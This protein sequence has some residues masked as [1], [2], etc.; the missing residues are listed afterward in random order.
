MANAQQPILIGSRAVAKRGF[1][2][3][4]VLIAAAMGIIVTGVVAESFF[5]SWQAQ[6]SQEIYS[7]LQRAS[8]SSL[9]EISKQ[10]WNATSVTSSTILGGT[11]YTSGVSTLVL[12]LPPLNNNGDII[13]GDDYLIFQQNGANTV[14]LISPNASSTRAN[15]TTPITINRDTELLEFQY[16]NAAGTELI[17]G[18]NDLTST[19]TIT[20]TA[21]SSRTLGSRIYKRE[22]KSTILLRNKAV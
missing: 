19:R 2:L 20:M 18:V 9:D 5:G 7:E 21:Q 15:L 16:F 8:R 11:T 10:T 13:T 3:I 17:P 1:T 14:R 12:R 6:R 22:I 4:E